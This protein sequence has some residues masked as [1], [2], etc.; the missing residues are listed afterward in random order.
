MAECNFRPP[1]HYSQLPWATGV[2]VRDNEIV[3]NSDRTARALPPVG[4]TP[5]QYGEMQL[6]GLR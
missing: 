5:Y 4:L 3:R 1:E 2:R 6:T